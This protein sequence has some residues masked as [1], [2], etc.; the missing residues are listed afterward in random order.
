MKILILVLVLGIT[1]TA[2]ATQPGQCDIPEL[3]L[4][5]ANGMFNSPQDAKYSLSSLQKIFGNKFSHYDIAYNANESILRQLFQILD[6]KS[7]SLAGKFWVF[8]N[9]FSE[10]PPDVVQS[11]AEILKEQA[12]SR[13]YVNDI[14]LRKHVAQYREKIENG[15]NVIIMS[16]SQGNFYA[17]FA[18]EELGMSMEPFDP[19]S[20]KIVAI[21]TPDANVAGSDEPYTTLNSD[22]V[23]RLIPMSLPPNTENSP[24][25]KFDH[26]FVKH[27][28]L[29]NRSGPKIIDDIQGTMQQKIFDLESSPQI[30]DRGY[31][32]E[33][34]VPMWKWILRQYY[35][36]KKDLSKMECLASTIFFKVYNWAGESCAGRSLEV[37]ERETN[38]CLK[39]WLDKDKIAYDCQ[40]YGLPQNFPTPFSVNNQEDGFFYTHPECK[41]NAKMLTNE[42]SA[43]LVDQALGFIAA[44]N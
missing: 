14:D 28:L 37:L 29:G 6:Q 36:P 26:Q 12:L 24:A 35:H 34:L 8:L 16:H 9:N 4:F 13:Q 18:F 10:T 25:G 7:A 43:R 42:I 39:E 22:W 23:V 33:S 31:V 20:L 21:A 41:W 15:E 1:N 32:E 40:L 11:I 30:E 19:A 5:Y 2:F 3:N 38:K 27:Y 17:N 44:P